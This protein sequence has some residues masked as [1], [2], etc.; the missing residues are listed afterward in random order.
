VGPDAYRSLPN[1]LNDA[2]KSGNTAMNVQLSLHETYADISP[3]RINKMSKTAFVSIQ[4]GCNNMCSFCIVPF[5]RGKERSR[6]ISSILDEIRQ[7]ND[8]GIKEV[9]LL[10]QNVNSYQDLSEF[11]SVSS[12]N[13]NEN[14]LSKGFKSNYRQ[15]SGGKTFTD[16]LDAVSLINP[17]M[18]IRFTSPHPKQ[19]PLELIQ[20]MKERV[21]ICKTIHLP[22]QSGSTSCLERMR[23]GY[24]REAYLNLVEQIRNILPE[25]AFTSDFISG[26]CGE[27]EQEHL[28]T[29]SLIKLVK[30]TFCFM[31]PYSMR[32][33][34]KAYY[35]LKDD[36]DQETKSRRYTEMVNVFR[37]CAS[38][39]NEMK[40]GQ[41]HL[42]LVDMISK[43]S[44]EY[45]SGRNDQNNIVVF[46]KKQI[47]NIETNKFELP[48][49]GDYVAC[50]ILSSTSQ[51][52][53]AEP[54]FVCNLNS[55]NTNK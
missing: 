5:T 22:A 9:T 47:N 41:I 48:Q 51:S 54:L 39:L 23:R 7:L 25:C 46:P 18:R 26:F 42:V 37:A 36:V 31:Y 15:K 17:E 21:N 6:N 29:L 55:F 35:H 4:R 45:L 12:T 24:S 33:K 32:E 49:I 38:E 50:K 10:G 19:F 3:I 30:Y 1:L 34:T 44:N 40:H 53:K 16:L 11:S 8:S 2:Y 52:L 14:Q 27:T 13:N 20:L 28:D 43:R